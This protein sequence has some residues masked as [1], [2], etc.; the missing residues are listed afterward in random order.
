MSHNK[1]IGKLM[2]AAPSSGSGK[3][4]VS[5]ALMKCFNNKNMSVV[6]YKCGPDYID[7]MY[8]KT[9]IG[10][11]STN[12]DSFFMEDEAIREYFVKKN[13]TYNGDIAIIEGVMG[14]YDGLGGISQKGSAYDIA[15]ILDTPIILVIDARGM[16][17]SILP[18]I[19]GFLKYDSHKLIKGVILNKTTKSFY[20][21]I[22]PIIE[23]ELG[24]NVCG[25]VPKNEALNFES[26]HLGLKLPN[27][28]EQL[29]DN[30][31]NAAE[32]INNTI[33]IDKLVCIANDK[34]EE[35]NIIHDTIINNK[36]SDLLRLAVAKD[37]AFCFY[38]EHNLDL[39]RENG[40]ELVYF[41]PLKDKK[42]PEN[43][44]GILL[45]GGYPELY[46]K[47]LSENKP[48]ISSI[49]SKISEGVPSIAECGGFMYLHEKLIDK[50]NNS[51]EMVGAH[52]GCVLYTG[53]LVRF[54][55]VNISDKTNRFLGVGNTIKGHEF[56]YFDSSNNG[57]DCIAKKP[58]GD[59]MWSCIC[60]KENSWWG[61]P[62]LYYAS[63]PSFVSRFRKCMLEYKKR[64]RA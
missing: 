8:H 54:G 25:Y 12:I 63:N 51:Y 61:F 24:I 30:L 44:H 46:A 7:P 57:E 35:K 34:N 41:S 3:T 20:D 31:S 58:I 43:I 42:L 6:A 13:T 38:Y 45:G 21:L 33:D 29:K 56:H 50:E 10:I 49:K 47:Q 15:S 17:K 39:L 4:V 28:I 55:Y 53:K 22:K 60:V 59:K 19:S 27:E 52:K 64:I 11:P 1:K 23:D 32:L 5:C 36:Q 14:L 2:I 18:L 37:E 40:I 48:M 62:H 26:R 16:G 9:I